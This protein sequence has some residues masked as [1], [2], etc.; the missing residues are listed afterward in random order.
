MSIF[1]LLYQ[2]YYYPLGHF[3]DL[4]HHSHIVTSGLHVDITRYI[5]VDLELRAYYEGEPEGAAAGAAGYNEW[6]AKLSSLIG[7]S[8]T[9]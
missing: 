2:F 6:S 9:F 8:Y 5:V 7:L 4:D 3:D 1:S